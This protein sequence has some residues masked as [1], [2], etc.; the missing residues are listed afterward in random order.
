MSYDGSNHI[1]ELFRTCEI[2]VG[3]DTLTTTTF[4]Y[5]TNKNP[6]DTP[7]ISWKHVSST[8]NPLQAANPDQTIRAGR[9]YIWDCYV[10]G[11]FTPTNTGYVVNPN[12]R[13]IGRNTNNMNALDTNPSCH[14]TWLEYKTREHVPEEAVKVGK[15]GVNFNYVARFYEE[16][17]SEMY[18]YFGYYHPGG[19]IAKGGYYGYSDTTI[20]S[21]SMELLLDMSS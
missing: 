13:V 11:Y 3:G 4:L 5:D 14:F 7:C 10:S 17:N 12:G 1:C 16:Q 19:K 15:M 8:A 18:T 6:A 9:S 2:L 20:K 21:H